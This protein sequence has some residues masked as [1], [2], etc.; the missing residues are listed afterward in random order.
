MRLQEWARIE[1]VSNRLFVIAARL[2]EACRTGFRS[3]TARFRDGLWCRWE[4]LPRQ[5]HQW[6]DDRGW[7]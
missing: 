3:Q 1:R 2:A 4:T 7:Q 5:R 6:S